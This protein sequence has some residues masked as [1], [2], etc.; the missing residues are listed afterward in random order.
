LLPQLL[1]VVAPEAG[2]VQVGEPGEPFGVFPRL[3]LFTVVVP[4]PPPDSAPLTFA[5]EIVYTWVS[6]P[7]VYVNTA[8]LAGDVTEPPRF[9]RV[10]VP[11]RGRLSGL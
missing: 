4:G 3:P 1:L 11:L 2:L 8:P 10:A 7:F 5:A 6:P 9:D